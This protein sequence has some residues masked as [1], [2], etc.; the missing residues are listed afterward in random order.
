[1][2]VAGAWQNKKQR[3]CK[4][5][6]CSCHQQSL[7]TGHSR[8]GRHQHSHNGHK[9][10]PVTQDRSWPRQGRE[11]RN[12]GRGDMGRRR[13]P[14]R[15]RRPAL[16]VP[17]GGE[18]GGEESGREGCRRQRAS[19]FAQT[20]APVLAAANGEL[21]SPDTLAGPGRRAHANPKTLMHCHAKRLPQYMHKGMR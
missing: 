17:L 6:C 8:K 18:V 11:E 14:R 16:G 19:P 20:A 2:R 12:T 9:M 10:P 5:W 21:D 7:L 1:M 13:Q 4:M 15:L 3:R